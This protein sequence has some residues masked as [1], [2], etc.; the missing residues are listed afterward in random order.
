MKYSEEYPFKV[1]ALCM[2]KFNASEQ[3]D[4]VSA[5]N[6]VCL[7]NN[8]RI[9]IFSTVT[10]F[11]LKSPMDKAEEEIFDLLCP[12][13]FDAVVILAESFKYTDFPQKIADKVTNAGVTCFSI[14][15]SLE[16]C[17]NI[18]YDFEVAFEEIVR[19]VVEDHKF[20]KINFLAGQKDNPF[21]ETRLA[22]YKKVL[23]ENGIEIEEDRIGYGDF[24]E[25][26]ASRETDRF[27][28]SGK[29]IE[30]I[31]C[32]ND[33]MAM[34]V[35]R[36]LNARGIVVPDDIVVTGFD[37]IAIEKYH[38]PRL[39]TSQENLDE[40]A[41]I[42]VK[43]I[44]EKE[45]VKKDKY[46]VKCSFR[47]SE[48]CGCIR[49]NYGVE[50]L[51]SMGR[52]YFQAHKEERSFVSYVESFYDKVSRYGNNESLSDVWPKLDWFIN[53]CEGEEFFLMLNT[54]F[55]DDNMEIWPNVS[56]LEKGE[57]YYDISD[58]VKVVIDNRLNNFK[59]GFNIPKEKLVPN[60]EDC[61][62]EG[63]CL[64]ILPFHCQGS[65]VGYAAEAFKP[66]DLFY[67]RFYA[68]VMNLRQ[69]V[70]MHKF[71]IDQ[72][73]LYST[74]QLTKLLNRKGFY[75]QMQVSVQNAIKDKKP[76][77]MISLDMNW[78]KQTNDT[79]GHKEGDF[80][81]AKIADIMEKA[82]G[83]KGVCTRFGGD[84]FAIGFVSDNAEE[85]G[86]KIMDTIRRNIDSF[87]EKK[88]KPYSISVS[89]GMYIRIPKASDNLEKYIV[90]ADRLMYK[91]KAAFK[92]THTWKG[93]QEI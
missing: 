76:F 13:N 10:D 65:T 30:A 14:L 62:N 58:E 93:N 89:M 54:D 64:M 88:K 34:E 37:G 75:R 9:V 4:F 40:V 2:A 23:L 18:E 20:T 70:E 90:E 73:N 7:E 32:A 19:H 85:V 16:G 51:R 82:V 33:T 45:S 59:N 57:A 28:E 41:D 46:L 15:S 43:I 47:K 38:Y 67:A 39:T 26:P 12:E 5:F 83:K 86:R 27:M 74:D 71:R 11:Y 79:F 63:K 21:S 61:L 55:V 53:L 52:E 8:C 17:I 84:E 48:S 60:L 72:Q 1:I 92:E 80:S 50:D 42:I 31:I 69:I 24:W 35:C 44:N 68:F 36:N 49:H 56:P 6:K 81:L 91:D 22:C 78:L 66:D 29:E 25:Y 87:N 3:I 77:G